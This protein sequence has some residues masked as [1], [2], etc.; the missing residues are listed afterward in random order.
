MVQCLRF[1]TEGRGSIPAASGKEPACQCRRRKRPEFD[2]WVGNIP[3]K[4]EWKP[5]PVFL[6]GEFHEQRGLVGY[7]HGVAK[8]QT[9]LSN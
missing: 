2:P 8:S 3:W 5:T 9:R 6:P 4:R 7:I 1:H